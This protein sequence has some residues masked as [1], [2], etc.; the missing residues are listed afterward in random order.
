MQPFNF[1]NL[2]VI[3]I[4]GA[5]LLIGLYLPPLGNI[6][7]DIIYRST[8]VAGF[9]FTALLLLKVSKDIND[10]FDKY[11]RKFKFIR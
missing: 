4:G 7:A 8:L 2:L 3:L 9:Y 10:K 5:A 11:A 6:F 1:K